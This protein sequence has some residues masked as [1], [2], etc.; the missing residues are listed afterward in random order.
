MRDYDKNLIVIKNNYLLK[1]EITAC[2][3][4][5][6]L[7]IFGIFYALHEAVTQ[8]NIM[9][10]TILI[11]SVIS[12]ASI[13]F[14]LIKAIIKFNKNPL[15]IK[16]FNNKITYDYLTE[17]GEF[18]VF[19]LPK[20]HIVSIKWGFFPYAILNEKDE[21]WIT[22]TT[23]D[24]LGAYIFAPLNFILSFI[25]QTIY[26][27]V[28]FKISTYVLIRF[29][30]GIMAIPKNEYPSNEN[31]KFEWKSLFNCQILQGDYYGN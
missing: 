29:K 9:R 17:K 13:V 25:Y 19:E 26:C 31:I 8:I 28:N 24:K 14:L 3:F 16:I 5:L 1:R 12:A 30:G 22:E 23:D 6:P 10:Q 20:K 27:I 4:A 21:I 7:F 2:V 15:F 18:K 11:I